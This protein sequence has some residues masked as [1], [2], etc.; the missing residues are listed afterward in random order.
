MIVSVQLHLLPNQFEQN[1]L[2]GITG[3]LE[4]DGAK[5]IFKIDMPYAVCIFLSRNL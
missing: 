3:L 4:T 5:F 1:C 2:N